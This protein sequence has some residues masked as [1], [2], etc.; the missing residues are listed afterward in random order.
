MG[1]FVFSFSLLKLPCCIVRWHKDWSNSCGVKFV[2]ILLCISFSSLSCFMEEA[3]FTV[4]ISGWIWGLRGLIW[5]QG[6]EPLNG[7][8][9]KWLGL[10]GPSLEKCLETAALQEF[11]GVVNLSSA[12]RERSDWDTDALCFSHECVCWRIS[13]SSSVTVAEHWLSGGC[14]LLD[15][16]RRRTALGKSVSCVLVVC[17]C[18]ANK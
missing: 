3:S 9:G 4:F 14:S 15:A 17:W 7:F 6:I 10:E 16:D 1:D 2:T 18:A 13:V 11:S 12:E 5:F 8:S